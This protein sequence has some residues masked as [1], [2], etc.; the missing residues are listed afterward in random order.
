LRA[1][2][3]LSVYLNYDLAV[4]DPERSEQTAWSTD[5]CAHDFAVLYVRRDCPDYIGQ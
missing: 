2:Q 3:A 5:P 1:R 4:L